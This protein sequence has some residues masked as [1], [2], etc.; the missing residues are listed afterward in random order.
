[1]MRVNTLVLCV[2]VMSLA[3]ARKIEFH[4]SS[5]ND[6]TFDTV[7]C[8]VNDQIEVHLAENPTTGF[9]WMIPEEK[10]GFNSIWSIV[11]SNYEAS[12][13]GSK[14]L[15]S[16]GMRTFLLNCDYAGVEHLTFVYGRPEL[17]DRAIKEW[18]ETG[19]FDALTMGGKAIQLKISSIR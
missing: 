4:F 3:F 15:G 6:G 17:Y 16:G 11:N 10:E 12:P 9:T 8:Q 19:T 7:S 18:K 1:M 14:T 5:L 13:S 2:M